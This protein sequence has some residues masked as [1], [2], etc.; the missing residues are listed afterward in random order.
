MT[1]RAA[2][3]AKATPSGEFHSFPHSHKFKTVLIMRHQW[4][5]SMWIQSDA[6]RMYLLVALNAGRAPLVGIEG[7]GGS[8]PWP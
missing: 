4:P 1:K 8:W 5:G 7:M 2:K 6:G 3:K